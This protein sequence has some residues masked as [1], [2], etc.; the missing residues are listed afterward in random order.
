ME[1][2]QLAELPLAFQIIAGFGLF[3]GTFMLAIGGWLWK[4]IKPKLPTALTETVEPD[5]KSS[6]VIV[7]AALADSHSI[8][9]L[10]SSIDK[11]C[12]RLVDDSEH[13]DRQS[14]RTYRRLGDVVDALDDLKDTLKRIEKQ[15]KDSPLT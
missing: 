14:E 12:E 11:L 6:A 13:R 3:F 2:K 5:P 7:G 15:I 8:G 10:A 9:K 1:A 4:T